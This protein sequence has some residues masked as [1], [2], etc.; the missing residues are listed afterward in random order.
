MT[1]LL[2][3]RHAVTES[4]GKRLTPPEAELSERGKGQADAVAER[5]RPIPLAAVY[6]SPMVRC[7]ETARPVA[8]SHGLEVVEVP[9]VADVDYGR[10]S[11]RP[12]TQFARS[13][14]WNAA[15]LSPSS[16]RF[17]D[18]ETLS[19]VLL[20]SIG[21]LQAI[22]ARHRR[23]VVAVVTHADV[24]RLAI[25]HYAGAHADMF[26]RLVVSP[27]SVSAVLLGDR[28]PRILRVNDI[29]SLADLVPRKRPRADGRGPS[30]R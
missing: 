5:L 3:V 18:G 28:A 12:L 9:Q 21:A 16:F 8:A 26:E 22:A 30:Q 23:R 6:A 27:A 2:L 1:L 15:Q 13:K 14:A 4:T 25:G 29:G 19:E 7:V 11:G 10:W 24:V 20:R 17:P